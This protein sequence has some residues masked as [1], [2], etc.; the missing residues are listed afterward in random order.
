MI[1][2]NAKCFSERFDGCV[3]TRLGLTRDRS[4][5]RTHSETELQSNLQL[6]HVRSR[7]ADPA[8][9]DARQCRIG[10]SPIRMIEEIERLETEFQIRLLGEMK[11]FGQREV[12]VF[13]SGAGH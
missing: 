6:T 7:R 9:R 11:L 12:P 8:K 1:A 5:H 4:K 13:D 3:R 10:I 2:K